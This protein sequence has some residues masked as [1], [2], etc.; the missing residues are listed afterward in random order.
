M[1]WK[2]P[3]V[4]YSYFTGGGLGPRG[5]AG[6]F[7]PAGFFHRLSRA[8]CPHTP[9]AVRL[10][11][12]T[13][14]VVVPVYRSQTGLAFWRGP[15][16]LCSYV[17]EVFTHQALPSICTCLSG[18]LSVWRLKDDVV[19]SARLFSS[20]WAMCPWCP[21]SVCTQGPNRLR[22]GADTKRCPGDA[23]PSLVA[24]GRWARRYLAD[25][26]GQCCLFK[27]VHLQICWLALW[28]LPAVSHVG[29]V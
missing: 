17:L 14:W 11:A 24:Y 18:G 27:C 28:A 15:V 16:P 22:K 25:A 10:S 20:L 23:A 1:V 2:G 6:G 12:E 3:G 26:G 8:L 5:A 13:W 19:G 21:S 29:P 7:S 4:P 9:Q